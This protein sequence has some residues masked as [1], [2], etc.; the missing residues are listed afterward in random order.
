MYTSLSP[1]RIFLLLSIL[2]GLLTS[3]TSV[4]TRMFTPA[5]TASSPV[6]IHE[7]AV[8]EEKYGFCDGVFLTY[9]DISEHSG[10]SSSEWVFSQSIRRTYLVLHP[11]AEPMS[12]FVFSL[13]SHDS[14]H[15]VSLRVTSPD[16]TV[17]SYDKTNLTRKSDSD[18]SSTVRFAYPGIVRGSVVEEQVEILAV[19]PTEEMPLTWFRWLQLLMPCEHLHVVYAYPAWWG[20]SMKELLPGKYPDVSAR[21]DSTHNKIVLEYTGRNV[22]AFPREDYAPFRAESSPY[23]SLLVDSLK[24]GGENFRLVDS[25]DWYAR[26]VK[27]RYMDRYPFINSILPFLPTDVSKKTQQLTARS[28]NNLARLDTIVR[29]LQH[30]IEPDP[31]ASDL[32]FADVLEQRRGSSFLITGLAQAMLRQVGIPS[33]YL[34]IHSAEQGYFDR[35]FFSSGETNVPALRVTLDNKDYIVFPYIRYMPINYLPEFCHGQPAMRIDAKEGFIGLLDLPEGNSEQQQNSRNYTIEINDDGLMTVQET[36]S[37]TGASAL[38]LR[39]TLDQRTEEEINEVLR[40]FISYNDGDITILESR[41]ENQSATMKPLLLYCTYTVDNLVTLT[42]G[43]VIVRTDGLLSPATSVIQKA[44]LSRRKLPV[45]IY[46]NEEY[47]KDITLRYPTSW[48]LSALPGNM[49][50]SNRF[51]ELST[52]YSQEGAHLHIRHRRV[53]QRTIQEPDTYGEL[54]DLIRENARKEIAPLIFTR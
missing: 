38:A 32:S 41:V 3:C 11:D 54:L 28:Y 9:E 15:R 13:S 22:E 43:E 49:D 21:L 1:V 16:G 24:M 8:Y 10:T 36:I 33:V 17:Q 2:S 29:Y 34:R 53:L 48:Q 12:T 23:M 47:I 4:S 20:I 35:D 50:I 40:K 42:P 46:A 37:L 6:E 19:D 45:R 31:A 27:K 44:D 51:G 14:L 5:Q 25:W 26:I 39:Q 30:T 18:S 52:R 7:P